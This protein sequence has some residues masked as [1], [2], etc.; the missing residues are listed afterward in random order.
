MKLIKRIWE[1]HATG[2]IAGLIGVVLV[3]SQ[4]GTRE[5]NYWI[6]GAGV[7]LL[8]FCVIHL[9]NVILR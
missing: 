9:D 6:A 5:L 7:L 4:A 1:E 8:L 3:M 2:P